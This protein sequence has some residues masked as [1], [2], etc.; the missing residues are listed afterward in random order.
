MQD[1]GEFRFVSVRK[2]P[3]RYVDEKL[4]FLPGVRVMCKQYIVREFSGRSAFV[5]LTLCGGL[6]DA[7]SDV[8]GSVGVKLRRGVSGSCKPEEV[9][10][11]CGYG[12]EG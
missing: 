5:L 2:S 3:F 4:M 1:I 11:F 7:V 12:G 10:G 8:V 6:K 9:N